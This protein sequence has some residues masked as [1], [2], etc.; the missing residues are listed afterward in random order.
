[1]PS[2]KKSTALI[3]LAALA[4]LGLGGASAFAEQQDDAQELQ[5]L[6][7]SKMSLAEAVQA[8]AAGLPLTVFQ[9]QIPCPSLP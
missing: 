1:M 9:S 3:G 2:K 4:T 5:R 7:T 8:A 6:E